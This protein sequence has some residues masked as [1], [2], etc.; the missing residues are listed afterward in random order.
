MK[1]HPG[2]VTPADDV[3]HAAA[4]RAD[5][6]GRRDGA[7]LL[8]L[9]HPDLTWTTHTGAVLDRIRYLAD[10]SAE[11]SRWLSQTLLNPRVTVIGTAAVLTATVVDTLDSPE[12]PVSF[13]MPMT[14]VWVNHDHAWLLLAG[15]AGPRLL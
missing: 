2:L 15:H 6:L 4:A 5:A 10:K 11:Q 14:Q 7:A 3:I 9:H 13:T 1:R 8:A 12:G